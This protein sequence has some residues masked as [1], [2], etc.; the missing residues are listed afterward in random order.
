MHAVL[1]T[2]HA[3]LAVL[4]FL[5]GLATLSRARAFWVYDLSLI[6]SMAAL[7]GAVA[8]DWSGLDQV[9]RALFVAFL[10]LTVVMVGQAERARRLRSREPDRRAFVSAIGFTLVALADGFGVIA[11][12][13]LGAALWLII[14]AGVVIAVIGHRALVTYQ[15]RRT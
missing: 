14:V 15:R 1:I 12:L 5:A 10:A 3:A 4:A 13:D 11:V 8:T 2:G 7:A 9:S 6:A